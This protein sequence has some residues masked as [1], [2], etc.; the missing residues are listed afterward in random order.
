MKEYTIGSS[1]NFGGFTWQILDNKKDALLLITDTIIEQ[2]SYHD[3]YTEI[4]WAGCAL[5]SY[6]NGSFYDA[7]SEADKAR[8]LPVTNKNPNNEWY[9][10]TGGEE[11]EDH[12]FLLSLEEVACM[13]FGDSSTNL[14]RPGKNQRYWFQRKDPNNSKRLA[15]L[16]DKD[17]EWWWLRSPGR[18]NVKAAYIHGTDGNIG[19]QGNN[20]LK[21]NISDGRCTG[22]VRPT[23]WLKHP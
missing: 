9:N 11:T 13:Y 2:R 7:F 22:G 19:I 5:R 6:L 12:I 10:T 4:T 16:L 14:Y 15:K 20:I 17:G 3:A 23:L 21:G 1:L 8:I 18:V